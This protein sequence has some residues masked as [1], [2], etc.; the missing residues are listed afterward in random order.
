MWEIFDPRDGVTVRVVR[1]AWLARLVT[2]RNGLDYARP[3]VGFGTVKLY[4]VEA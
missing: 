4:T 2:Y 1:W 3:G